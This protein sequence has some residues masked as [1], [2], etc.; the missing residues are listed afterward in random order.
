MQ[1]LVIGKINTLRTPGLD[2]TCIIFN[3]IINSIGKF[4]CSLTSPDFFFNLRPNSNLN[5]SVLFL[6]CGCHEGK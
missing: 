1:K 2:V 3:I 5:T 6:K 4:N